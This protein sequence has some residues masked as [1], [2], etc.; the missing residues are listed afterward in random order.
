[1]WTSTCGSMFKAFEIFHMVSKFGCF[2]PFSIAVRWVLDMFA[3]P[4]RT[5]WVTSFSIRNR[6]ITI[7]IDLLSNSIVF[8][9][10]LI[11]NDV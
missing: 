3:S 5:S 2:C 7:P 8:P 11:I 4:L 9:L 6:R 10:L 1:M